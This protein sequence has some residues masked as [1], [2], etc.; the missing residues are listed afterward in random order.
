MAAFSKA[1]VCF[2]FLPFFILYYSISIKIN[3]LDLMELTELLSLLINSL[4]NPSAINTIRVGRNGDPITPI[5][6]T[7]TLSQP[8]QLECERTDVGKNWYTAD[9][10]TVSP[11]SGELTTTS[12]T[13]RTL[14]ISS[15]SPSHAKGYTC[16]VSATPLSTYPVKLGE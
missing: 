2:L 1:Q 5:T 14:S 11:T 6:I 3:C 16:I 12:G 8:V 15:F 10:A 13:T 4:V 9:G 7:P